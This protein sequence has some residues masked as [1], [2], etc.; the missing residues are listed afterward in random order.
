MFIMVFMFYAK[1]NIIHWILNST[2]NNNRKNNKFD[3]FSAKQKFMQYPLK[4]HN[5]NI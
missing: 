5:K 4:K 2:S 3:Y 1:L